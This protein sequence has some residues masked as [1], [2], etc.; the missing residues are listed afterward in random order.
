M[1]VCRKYDSL[2]IA[3][4]DWKKMYLPKYKERGINVSFKTLLVFI[5][6]RI[7]NF[8]AQIFP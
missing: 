6:I 4:V 8:S 3:F 2:S 5:I 7:F 1:Q